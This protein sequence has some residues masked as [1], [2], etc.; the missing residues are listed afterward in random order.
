MHHLVLPRTQSAVYLDIYQRK[1]SRV[2]DVICIFLGPRRV[3]WRARPDD[4]VRLHLP[5]VG[6][7][8]HR[9]PP[10]QPHHCQQR[11]LYPRTS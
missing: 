11:L 1:S 10:L 9:T 3:A 2:Y 5:D 4:R 7:S 8:N 6:F